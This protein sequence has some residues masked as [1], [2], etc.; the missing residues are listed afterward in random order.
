MFNAVAQFNNIQISPKHLCNAAWTFRVKAVFDI[1]SILKYIKYL[2]VCCKE[3]KYKA[4]K[5]NNKSTIYI[6]LLS[7]RCSDVSF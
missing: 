2:T 3:S 4:K 1:K 7:G 6:F 5:P